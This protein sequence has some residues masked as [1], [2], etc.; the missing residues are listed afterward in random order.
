MS[1]AGMHSS[2]VG[3]MSDLTDKQL[4]E[5]LKSLSENFGVG[6]KARA[7]LRLAAQRLEATGEVTEAMAERARQVYFEHD[8]GSLDSMRAALTAALNGEE[9]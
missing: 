3:D 7:N 8:G 1:A 2:L 4:A 9:G 6:T 5:A